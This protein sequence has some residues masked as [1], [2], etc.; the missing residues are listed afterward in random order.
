MTPTIDVFFESPG[1]IDL[2]ATLKGRGDAVEPALSIIDSELPIANAGTVDWIA[3]DVRRRLVIADV[4]GAAPDD[5]VTRL[6][7]H[8]Q[9]FS[10]NLPIVRRMYQLWNVNWE[11]PIRALGVVQ[12]DRAKS[13][14]AQGHEFH[15]YRNAVAVEIICAR[16][17]S[18]RDG[19]TAVVLSSRAELA[20]HATPPSAPTR[21]EH[22]APIPI[23]TSEHLPE[24]I[25][26]LG[27]SVQPAERVFSRNTTTGGT[28]DRHSQFVRYAGQERV[29][30]REETYRRELGLT[31]EEFAEFFEGP[32]AP[33]R[34]EPKGG[35]EGGNGSSG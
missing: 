27:L 14:N 3:L 30:S 6:A 24:E 10:E 29:L 26:S 8:V 17:V 32:S 33:T 19:R 21:V 28:H 13:I 1:A 16:I 31:Q 22:P 18:T 9:W 35:R 20:P 25:S 11:E 7:A 5:V 12:S 23:P 15:A 4:E 2:R 34:L